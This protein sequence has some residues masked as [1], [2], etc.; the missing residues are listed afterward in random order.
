MDGGAGGPSVRPMATATAM[1]A[2]FSAGTTL[3]YERTLTDLPASAYGWTLSLYLAGPTEARQ[4]DIAL[5]NGVYTVLLPA[6]TTQDLTAGAYRWLERV[7]EVAPGTRVFDV[8]SG[9]VTVDPDL[10]SA[11]G[12]SGVSYEAQVLAA[13][14]AKL[15]DR[16]TADQETLQVDGTAIARIPFERLDSLIAKYEAI[17]EAQVSPGAVL[18]SIEIHFGRTT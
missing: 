9:F 18:G 10:A 11:T 12:G 17:V 14:K 3:T 4:E 8:A 1:P 2:R 13:L 6:S 16:L 15:L 5:A 7:K